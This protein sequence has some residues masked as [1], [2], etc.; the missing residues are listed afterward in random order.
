MPLEGALNYPIKGGRLKHTFSTRQLSEIFFNALNS[1][2]HSDLLAHLA[3]DAVLDFPG[4]GRIEGRRRIIAFVRVLFRK[5]PRLEFTIHDVIVEK[6]RACVVWTN[7]GERA[8]G[9]AYRNS[10]ITFA[11]INDGKIVYIS[12]YFKDTSFAF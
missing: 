2:D 1:R 12:D 10:G 3:E 7:R 4:A 5:F 9:D 6:E 8:N 11:K